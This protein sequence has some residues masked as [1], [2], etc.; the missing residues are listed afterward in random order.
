MIKHSRII[1]N[2]I[3]SQ[4]PFTSYAEAESDPSGISAAFIETKWNEFNLCMQNRDNALN[5]LSIDSTFK[6]HPNSLRCF[7]LSDLEVGTL[8]PGTRLSY[9]LE[10]DPALYYYNRNTAV[11]RVYTSPHR[12]SVAVTRMFAWSNCVVEG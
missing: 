6:F 4:H 12:P 3:I 8:I 10:H 2:L 7:A 9:Y 1:A 11:V 5:F